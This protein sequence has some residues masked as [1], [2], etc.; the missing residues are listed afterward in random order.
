MQAFEKRVV[1]FVLHQQPRGRETNLAGVGEHSF[2]HRLQRLVE[3]RVRK[4]QMRR[5]AAQLQRHRRHV[6]GRLLHD[7]NACL[8]RTRESYMIDPRI[9][10]KRRPPR[11]APYPGTTLKTPAGKPASASSAAMRSAVQRRLLRRLQHHRVP[12][13][14]RRH[15]AAK[16]QSQRIIPR[17][18]VRRDPNRFA[19]GVVQR[20]RRNRDRRPEKLV[21]QP[22]VKFT[23]RRRFHD[24]V[25]CLL[26]RFPGVQTFQQRQLV[27]RLWIHQQ[28]GKIK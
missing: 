25:L 26:D 10:R 23:S 5:F 12:A 7:L 15:D 19:H 8:H 21:H 11:P 3:I 6:S 28:P 17:G 14:Q 1:N 2:H 13:R 22:A 27:G 4:N 20:F 24:V 9:S 18:D 16:R